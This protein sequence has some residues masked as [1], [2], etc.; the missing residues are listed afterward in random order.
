VTTS[1]IFVSVSCRLDISRKTFNTDSQYFSRQ[2]FERWIWIR[3][4]S[5]N[6]SRHVQGASN[7]A[8]FNTYTF[9]NSANVLAWHPKHGCSWDNGLSE[10]ERCNN[11]ADVIVP[12]YVGPYSCIV[13]FLPGTQQ[14]RHAVIAYM[15]FVH[16]NN[17]VG[18]FR[19]SQLDPMDD[20]IRKYYHQSWG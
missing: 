7:N 6:I 4:C 11:P 14:P 9:K 20:Y 8:I 19:M 2:K 10:D 1:W 12:H 5:Q 3:S 16:R 13:G 15:M 17:T 18:R